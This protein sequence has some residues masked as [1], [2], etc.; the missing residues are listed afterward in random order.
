MTFLISSCYTPKNVAYFQDATLDSIMA[1]NSAS[2]FK[3]KE[4]DKINIVVNSKNPEMEALFNLRFTKNILGASHQLQRRAESENSHGGGRI[5]YYTVDSNGNID[6]PILGEVH[7]S[8]LT[9]LEVGEMIEQDLK[10]KELV[11]DAVVTV[12]YVNISITVLGDVKKSGQYDINKDKYTILDAIADAGDLTITGKRL[13]VAVLRNENGNLRRYNINLNN[14]KE[15]ITSPGYFLQQ[16]D[17]V[18]VE[19]NKMHKLS[20][21]TGATSFYR[22]ALWIS[23]ASLLVAIYRLAFK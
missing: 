5:G 4:G 22:P 2:A 17:I 18:Y 7:V 15:T 6:F 10:T 9:R 16:N 1:I 3:L 8:G 19:P 13:N 12:E 14:R 23:F 20:S 21:K 11:N